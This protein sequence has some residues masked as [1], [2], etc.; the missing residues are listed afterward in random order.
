MS[1]QRPNP[2]RKGDVGMEGEGEWGGLPDYHGGVQQEPGSS[3]CRFISPFGYVKAL[4][5][6]R[7][8]GSYC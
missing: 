3:D 4:Q 1:N 7:C 6:Y 5:V 8:S 2:Q